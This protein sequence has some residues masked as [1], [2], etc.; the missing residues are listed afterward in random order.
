MRPTLRH[1]TRLV[2]HAVKPRRDGADQVTVT[3][4]PAV[5]CNVGPLIEQPALGEQAT[6]TDT[7]APDVNRGRVM[8]VPPT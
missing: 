8:V 4:V 6:V 5:T 7:G 3:D 1:R 2:L